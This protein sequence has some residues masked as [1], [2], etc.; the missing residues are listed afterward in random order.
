MKVGLR[1]FTW[2]TMLHSLLILVVLWGCAKA[3][4]TEILE[5]MKSTAMVFWL[6]A[7]ALGYGAN[8]FSKFAPNAKDQGNG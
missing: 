6:P 8:L 5:F 2:G 3:T 1:K 7:L 4:G